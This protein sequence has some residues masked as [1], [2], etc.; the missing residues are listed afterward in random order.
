MSQ[1]E[2]SQEILSARERLAENLGHLDYS[3]S[4]QGIKDKAKRLF[5]DFYHDNSGQLR[6]DRVVIT[7]VIAIFALIFSRKD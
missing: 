1:E 3:L 6:I 5:K 4:A 7:A 2:I